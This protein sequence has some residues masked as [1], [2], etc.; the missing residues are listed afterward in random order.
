MNVKYINAFIESAVNVLKVMAFID[1]TPGKPYAKQDQTARGDFSGLIT[2]SGSVT[3]SLALSFSESCIYKIVSNM[4]GE[5][6]E[7]SNMVKNA[8]GELTNMISGDAR[9]R[10]QSQGLIIQA[11]IPIILSGKDH[12][13]KH[14]LTGPSIIVPFETAFGAFVVD[15]NIKDVK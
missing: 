11:D 1:A 4:L 6:Q 13:I 7:T 8:A 14:V 5:N 12:L 9:K 2:F 15:I 3:G 10:L